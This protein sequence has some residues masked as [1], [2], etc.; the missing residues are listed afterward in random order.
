[1]D[2]GLKNGADRKDAALVKLLLDKGIPDPIT[3]HTISTGKGT[4]RLP[5]GTE[6]RF[7]FEKPV[8]VSS[9]VLTQPENQQWDQIVDWLAEVRQGIRRAV[10]AI[11]DEPPLE[12]EEGAI[13]PV[14]EPGVIDPN[15]PKDERFPLPS[16]SRF[17][18]QSHPI[19]AES[20]Q[21]TESI[22]QRMVTYLRNKNGISVY[23]AK[24]SLRK[25]IKVNGNEL[26]AEQID[27]LLA[28]LQQ[29]RLI[30][31]QPGVGTQKEYIKVL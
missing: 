16:K 17:E 7:Q 9:S 6:F 29:K 23:K 30:E 26:K 19:P 27:A 28:L 13:G 24:Q 21:I 4:L 20:F 15:Q 31:I 2:Y 1:M 18:V 12:V 8:E 11:D 25:L 10:G 3:G 14:D 5:D 22:C